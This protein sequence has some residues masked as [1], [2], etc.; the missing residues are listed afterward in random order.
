MFILHVHDNSLTPALGG[1]VW[2]QRQGNQG[3]L[4]GPQQCFHLGPARAVQAHQRESLRML[5]ILQLTVQV[6]DAH[7]PGTVLD[8]D[9]YLVEY[10]PRPQVSIAGA[11]EEEKN[12]GMARRTEFCAGDED[13]IALSFSGEAPFELGYR[14]TAN[15]K[16][17]RHTLKS[18]QE[19]GILY[20]ATDAGHHRYDIIDLKDANY[21][22]NPASIAIDHE[23]YQR[24][25]ATFVKPNTRPLCLDT[26]LTGDA[27]VKLV[28]K[29][30]FNLDVAVR[31]P[32]SAQIETFPVEV[33]KNEWTLALPY[34]VRDVGRYEVT[35]VGMGDAS[36]CAWDADDGQLLTTTVEVVESARIVPVSSEI[37]LCEG[38]SL[39][40]LLQGKSPWVI[41]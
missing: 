33:D 35:I 40:F 39:D 15:G 13:Q 27:Q 18:A 25:S 5:V 22:K 10:K 34:T 9:W 28:G 12:R 30:P 8:E 41:E 1:H 4:A 3:D 38:D 19:T 24:P 2:S 26:T 32:A 14:Y 7:C 37:D 21:A 31:R 11:S 29:P 16:T 17:S 23:V 20:L 6:K 36:G